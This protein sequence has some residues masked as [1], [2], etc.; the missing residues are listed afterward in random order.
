[1]TTSVVKHHPSRLLFRLMPILLACSLLVSNSGRAQSIDFNAHSD[2]YRFTYANYVARKVVSDV[3]VMIMEKRNDSDEA[4]HIGVAAAIENIRLGARL[5][6]TSPGATDVMA[7][8]LGGSGKFYL[9]RN[10]SFGLLFYYAP[11][12]SSFLDAEGYSEFG[13]RL[14]FVVS[15][16]LELYVGYRNYKVAI[17][18]VN[19]K[20]ELDD[21][22][23]LGL[24]FYF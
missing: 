14:N 17:A 23:H 16:P 6:Y 5:I 2:V 1:M 4:W 3:G 10:I 20:I 9:S 22:L 21:D 13:M 24:K 12:F 11:E 7:V 8:G 15:K 18:D 19:N